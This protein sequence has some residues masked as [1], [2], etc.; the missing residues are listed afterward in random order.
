MDAMRTWPVGHHVAPAHR[1][2]SGNSGVEKS[3]FC[4][5]PTVHVEPEPCDDVMDDIPAILPEQAG[6]Y[7]TEE[8]V[9]I[10]DAEWERFLQEL[11]EDFN[12]HNLENQIM[13]SMATMMGDAIPR[14][15]FLQIL[16]SSYP[17]SSFLP[18]CHGT[19]AHLALT[20]SFPSCTPLSC[21]RNSVLLFPMAIF[22]VQ[23]AEYRLIMIWQS[24]IPASASIT[25]PHATLTKAACATA[26]F[27]KRK[28]TQFSR[29]MASQLGA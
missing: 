14:S 21:H 1:R 8:K 2:V 11:Q 19:L 24:Q 9:P 3:A 23:L 6:K 16:P 13:D 27:S 18:A 7:F 22:Y 10:D 28:C 20:T 4:P 5:A 15:A 25:S 12:E 17:S 26:S 29:G